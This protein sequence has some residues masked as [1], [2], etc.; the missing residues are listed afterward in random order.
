MK[1][2]VL[3]VEDEADIVE[4]LQLILEEEGYTVLVA[5]NGVEG[6]AC[7]ARSR[8]DVILLDVMM[9]KM[10]GWE[11]CRHM[12]ENPSY[13]TIPV[14]MA[15]AVAAAPREDCSWQAFIKKPYH[16]DQVLAM[17]AQVLGTPRE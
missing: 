4:M 13:R 6:L 10:N 5:Y 12:Q 14:I 8:P 7:L 17:L 2:T 9:P 1:G 3:I 11:M 15:S 16:L